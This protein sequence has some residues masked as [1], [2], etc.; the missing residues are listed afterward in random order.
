MKALEKRDGLS[1][2]GSR[3]LHTDIRVGFIALGWLIDTKGDGF[4][5][6]SGWTF[7]LPRIA[8]WPRASVPFPLLEIE[9][10]DGMFVSNYFIPATP[11]LPSHSPVT[12]GKP[13][14]SKHLA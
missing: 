2:G 9:S 12:Q 8:S 3:S 10:I 7:G 11:L 6:R 5:D 1:A 13:R 14:L 4:G